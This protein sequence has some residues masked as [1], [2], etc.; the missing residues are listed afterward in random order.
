M[1]YLNS[2]FFKLILE[3]ERSSDKKRDQFSLRAK[4]SDGIFDYTACFFDK[5]LMV[6]NDRYGKEIIS[7]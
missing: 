6:Q 3:F 7:F 4:L 2:C 5:K 1:G